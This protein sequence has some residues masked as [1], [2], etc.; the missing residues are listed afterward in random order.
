MVGRDPVKFCSRETGGELHLFPPLILASPPRMQKTEPSSH[1]GPR[2][3]TEERQ[4]AVLRAKLKERRSSTMMTLWSHY[5]NAGLLTSRHERVK[6]T[7]HLFRA[8]L[9]SL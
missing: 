5:S 7:T 9:L 2:G 8:L 4:G 1:L 3:D 6:D